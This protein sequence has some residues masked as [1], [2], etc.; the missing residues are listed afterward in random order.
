MG[1]LDYLSNFCTVTSTRTKRKPMQTVEIKVRMDCDGCER[2][3]RNAVTSLKGVKSVE[4]N[5]KQS[6]VIVSGYVDPN[7]VLK[8]IR[9]TGKTRAQFWPYV[10][11]HLVYYPYAPGAYDRRAPSGYVRNV[12]Q[13]FPASSSSNAPSEENFVS[14]FSDDNVNA[15][16][17]M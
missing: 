4:V 8:R 17:I 16:S 15:C 6:K 11:Q 9:S 2:R 3:V 13:A 10:E 7:K 1:A 14:L 12:V 5:R